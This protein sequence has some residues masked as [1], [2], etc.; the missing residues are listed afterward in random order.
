[1]IRQI[2][3][4]VVLSAVL[5]S[6]MTAAAVGVGASGA[7]YGAASASATSQS[8]HVNCRRIERNIASLKR[9]STRLERQLIRAQSREKLKSQ[10]GDTTAANKIERKIGHLEARSARLSKREIALA[11]KCQSSSSTS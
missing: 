10:V 7:A 11:L 5:G 4:G 8:N 9:Q 2:G 3:A 1:M 6:G